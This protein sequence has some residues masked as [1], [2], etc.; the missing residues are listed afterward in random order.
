MVAKGELP[1]QAV[2]E[3][4]VAQPLPTPQMPRLASLRSQSSKVDKGQMAVVLTGRV[5]LAATAAGAALVQQL[6]RLALPAEVVV[7]QICSTGLRR[8]AL[9]RTAAATAEAVQTKLRPHSQPQGRPI[10]AAEAEAELLT[11]KVVLPGLALLTVTPAT[12]ATVAQV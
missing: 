3:A 10:Q 1:L 2:V 7:V 5:H 9:A 4:Q 6:S 12:A 11:D 8:R